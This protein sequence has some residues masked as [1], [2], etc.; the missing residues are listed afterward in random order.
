M[1]HFACIGPRGLILG[2]DAHLR[3]PWWSFSKTVIAACAML[4][5]EDGRLDLDTPQDGMTLRQLLGHRAGL[6]DYGGLPEYHAAVARGDT[7]WSRDRI[8]AAA[9]APLFPPGKGWSYSNIGT[10]LARDRI[11]TAAGCDLGQLVATRIA[12]PLGLDSVRLATTPQDFA[13]L[14]FEAQG[15]D[16][17][18]V[19][20]GCLSG[21]AQDAARLLHG[22][23]TGT[24]LR[25]ATLAMMCET[26]PLGGALPGRPWTGTGYALGLMSGQMGALRAMGHTGAGPFSTCAVYHFPDLTCTVACFTPDTGAGTAETAALTLALD[27]SRARST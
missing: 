25:S 22:L 23:M 2:G 4:L 5:V 20:H 8:I 1:E 26:H 10:M 6:P 15:Y 13:G 7:P 14:G 11:E 18:W 17:G 12:G 9:G 24:V 19:Y 27:Q 21:T 16:P 3:F